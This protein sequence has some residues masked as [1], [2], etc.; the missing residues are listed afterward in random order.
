MI[1]FYNLKL[2]MPYTSRE[3]YEFISKET[4]D[5][6]VEWK[7]CKV[8]GTAFPIYQSDLDFYEKISPVFNGKKYAI[9]TPT[10][11]PEERERRRLASFSQTCLY[12]NVC[13]K[14]HQNIISRFSP[15]SNI[16]NYC[17]ACW[18]DGDRDQLKF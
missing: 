8:S 3:V 12:H 2:K 10:L 18:S 17:N 16:V 9:P 11:C 15:T 6:I 7:S 14:C 1:L 5:P 4:N 13:A